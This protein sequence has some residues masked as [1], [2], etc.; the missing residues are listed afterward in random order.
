VFRHLLG[1]LGVGLVLLCL[2]GSLVG[3]AT[4]GDG[5]L[6]REALPLVGVLVLVL[7][8]GIVEWWTGR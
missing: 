4:C 8:V 5:A 2:M 6:A 1:A 3:I 7:A